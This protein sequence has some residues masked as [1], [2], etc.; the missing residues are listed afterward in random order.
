VSAETPAAP[1]TCIAMSSTFRAIFGAATYMRTRFTQILVACMT[2]RKCT[3]LNCLPWPSRGSHGLSYS[4]A[5]Q[6][7]RLLQEPKA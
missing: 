3:L 4:H 5:G 1:W 6:V 2:K 7:D